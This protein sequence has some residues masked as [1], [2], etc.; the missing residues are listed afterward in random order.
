MPHA[1]GPHRSL[2]AGQPRPCASPAAPDARAPPRGGQVTLKKDPV[3]L[4][5]ALAG[6]RTPLRATAG[7]RR[8]PGHAGRAALPRGARAHAPLGPAARR[9]AGRAPPPARV[10]Q[11]A[12]GRPGGPCL[13]RPVGHS[14]KRSLR[15][16][17]T[18][19][20]SA[21]LPHARGSLR[22]AVMCIRPCHQAHLAPLQAIP[23]SQLSRH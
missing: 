2:A 20:P 4:S 21:L 12:W 5:F 6:V 18:A 11:C 10:P 17:S 22:M 7:V 14:L 9:G 16:H 23:G 1:R 13:G 15:H 19:P 8:A 3:Q